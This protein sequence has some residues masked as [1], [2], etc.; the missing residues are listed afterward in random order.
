MESVFDS[1]SNMFAIAIGK[2]KILKLDES[3]AY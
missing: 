2:N 1:R 3:L